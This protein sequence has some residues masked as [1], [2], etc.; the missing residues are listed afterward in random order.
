MDRRRGSTQPA[1]QD[2]PGTLKSGGKFKIPKKKKISEMDNVETHSPLSRLTDSRIES[3]KASHKRWPFSYNTFNKTRNQ[4]SI[5]Y[6]QRRNC[7][8]K[9]KFPGVGVQLKEARIVLRDVL[10]TDSGRQHLL[11]VKKRDCSNVENTDTSH[12]KHHTSAT[13]ELKDNCHVETKTSHQ[14]S[15]SNILSSRGVQSEKRSDAQS[16]NLTRPKENNTSPRRNSGKEAKGICGIEQTEKGDQLCEQKINARPCEDLNE[17]RPTDSPLQSPKKKRLCAELQDH[18]SQRDINSATPSQDEDLLKKLLVC[19]TCKEQTENCHCFS[20]DSNNGQEKDFHFMGITKPE[21]CLQQEQLSFLNTKQQSPNCRDQELVNDDP[22]TPD[23]DIHRRDS[24]RPPVINEQKIGAGFSTSLISSSQIKHLKSAAVSSEP[25]VLSS[26]DEDTDKTQ[27]SVH[28]TTLTPEIKRLRL[29]SRPLSTESSKSETETTSAKLEPENM[30]DAYEVTEKNKVIDTMQ[31]MDCSLENSTMTKATLDL[32]FAAIHM[33]EIEGNEPGSVMFGRDNITISFS[34]L[35]GINYS[36]LL[37]TSHLKKYSLWERLFDRDF[38]NHSVIFLWFAAGYIDEVN[39]QSQTSP[40]KHEYKC[41]EFIF[42]QLFKPLQVMETAVLMK[43]M[44]DIGERNGI[45]D[46]SDIMPLDETLQLLTKFSLEQ[47]SFLSSCCKTLQQQVDMATLSQES[48]LS[49]GENASPVKPNNYTLCHMRRKDQYVVSIATKQ[50]KEKHVLKKSGPVQKIIVFPPPPT[51]G[52]LAVT[53]EDLECLEEGEFLNDV[54]IDFYLKYL[55]LEKAPK[56]LA[57]RT[58]IFSSFFYRRL[59]RK[60]NAGSEE[61]T[62]LS[63][64]HKRHQRV[65]T[66]TRH[67]DIFT[68][69]FIFV[70]VNE[71]SHWYLAVICF[72]ALDKIVYESD[73]TSETKAIKLLSDSS[74]TLLPNDEKTGKEQVSASDEPDGNSFQ[75]ALSL[76]SANKDSSNVLCVTSSASSN[77][78]IQECIKVPINLRQQKIRILKQPCILIMDSLRAASQLHTVK[79]LREYLQI[80]WEVKRRGQRNFT[81]DNMK[82]SVPRVPKQDNSSDCGIY[83]LQYVESFFQKPIT[84]FEL[85]LQLDK[86]FL[87]EEVKKKREEIQ[88][89]ILQLHS[90]QRTDS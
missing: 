48:H 82:G 10:M 27:S 86:W 47:S 38:E 26:D 87:R 44:T 81:A 75:S 40:S 25:I 73:L 5:V 39:K 33:G 8:S 50:E 19:L 29:G 72:P 63:V 13:S 74:S 76:D 90:Q 23:G 3:L 84:N 24:L 54:I 17:D 71:E 79:I 14:D 67:V 4:D 22:S 2:E 89:L 1:G 21:S 46:L 61:A 80:E 16:E 42:I 55:L 52:G 34:D 59:T 65:R 77:S 41:N 53:S 69:D 9:H 85:P 62:N 6:S 28:F 57:E 37:D 11:R 51:K 15:Q 30:K 49:R 64:Q 60:D 36:L 32:T 66:W 68:K 18:S 78:R 70:P 12:A 58:H 45:T 35:C 31:R 88:D 83:L 20:T 56:E 43:I 7:R